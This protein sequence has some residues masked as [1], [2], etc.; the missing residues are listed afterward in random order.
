MPRTATRTC[1]ELDDAQ[2]SYSQG[3]R[4]NESLRNA[5]HVCECVIC[6]HCRPDN[7]SQVEWDVESRG[8]NPPSESNTDG[9]TKRTNPAMLAPKINGI[10]TRTFGGSSQC[11]TRTGTEGP[12]DLTTVAKSV[13][14][15]R[16]VVGTASTKLKPRTPVLISR[17]MA[18]PEIIM[19]LGNY[20]CEDISD[21]LSYESCTPF[22]VSRGGQSN[23]YRGFLHNG[24]TIAIK[25]IRLDFNST[26]A[27]TTLKCAAQELYTWS[28]CKHPNV[29]RLLGLVAFQGQIGMVSPWVESGT[30]MQYL[31]RNPGGN[32]YRLSTQV[33]RGLKYLHEAGIVHGDLK[34]AN[35]LVS[36]NGIPMLTDFGSA[37]LKEYAIRFTGTTPAPPCSHRWAAP[38]IL[39]GN[40]CDN[41]GD[42]YALGMTILETFTGKV[43]YCNMNDCT[44]IRTVMINKKMPERPMDR[45]PLGN[46][47]G[48]RL[49]DLLMRCW[50]YAPEKRPTAAVVAQ[51]MKA[52]SREET[53]DRHPVT[54]FR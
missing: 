23:I 20:G 28:R 34:G 30:L 12:V 49:W 22:P 10:T 27:Q 32:R 6:K 17:S 29:H 24:S 46:M 15:L 5:P 21:T 2:L 31:S 9:Q 48:N 11:R 52:I 38:E 7:L 36:D 19:H 18:A 44:V 54:S 40:K 35:I 14:S 43:P 13:G 41:A 39:E 37:V 53:W 42:V 45:I 51:A 1:G 50:L 26:E 3:E 25:I 16:T 8:A 4:E 47:R 33:C